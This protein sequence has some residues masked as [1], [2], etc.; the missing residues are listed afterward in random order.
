MPCLITGSDSLSSIE[1]LSGSL[2][3]FE[4]PPLNLLKDVRESKPL[5]ML[6]SVE[7]E[8]FENVNQECD[9]AL[10]DFNMQKTISKEL[11][12]GTAVMIKITF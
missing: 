2:D 7:R 10:T 4:L 12:I 5:Q 9:P 8:F 1:I 6:I 3:S 11:L